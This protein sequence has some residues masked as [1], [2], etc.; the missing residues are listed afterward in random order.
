MDIWRFFSGHT[1]PFRNSG[2]TFLN[3]DYFFI[4]NFDYLRAVV[5]VDKLLPIPQV[6]GS[7][8]ANGKNL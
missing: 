8:P 6:S 1:G 4:S 2:A 5:V 3:S 7:N